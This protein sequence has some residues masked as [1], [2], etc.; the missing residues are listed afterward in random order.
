MLRLIASALV[1]LA[2]V[3]GTALAAKGGPAPGVT[4]GWDGTVD[5]TGAVRY[6]ALTAAKTTTIAAVRTTDGRVLRYGTIRG[7]F[8]IPLV[9]FDGTAEGVSRDGTTLVLA[10]AAARTDETRFAVLRTSTLRLAKAIRLPGRARG[11]WSRARAGKA[12]RE[13][14]RRRRHDDVQGDGLREAVARRPPER[15]RSPLR[16]PRRP[17]RCRGWR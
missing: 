11:G 14:A 13:P 17:R 7:G 9:A 4:V 12:G 5:S 3:T 8:G 16:S 1:V 15:P 6:V 2:L 10:D